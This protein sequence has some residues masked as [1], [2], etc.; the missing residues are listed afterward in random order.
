MLSE[1][2]G[3]IEVYIK[4]AAACP[5]AIAGM[6]CSQCSIKDAT[7]RDEHNAACEHELSP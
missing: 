5:N 7:V 2:S 1:F 4:G 3:T 6:P